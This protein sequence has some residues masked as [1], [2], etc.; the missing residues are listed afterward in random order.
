MAVLRRSP[1]GSAH[2]PISQT[3]GIIYGEAVLS[4]MGAERSTKSLDK[5]LVA[6]PM[7]ETIGSGGQRSSRNSVHY[8]FWEWHHEVRSIGYNR[9]RLTAP[10]VVKRVCVQ[11][12]E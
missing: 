11:S 7:N 3:Q 1:E 10:F 4:V 9:H 5:L 2:A 8:L 6:E 12:L